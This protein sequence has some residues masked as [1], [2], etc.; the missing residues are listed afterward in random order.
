VRWWDFKRQKPCNARGGR[1]R[2]HERLRVCAGQGSLAL[3]LIE[4]PRLIPVPIIHHL[5]SIPHATIPRIFV[6][7]ACV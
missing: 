3:P 7:N 1:M 2:K 4:L 6:L 5:V